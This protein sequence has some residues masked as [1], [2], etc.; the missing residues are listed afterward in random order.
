MSKSIKISP[1]HG[2]NP[3]I[4]KCFWCGESKNQIA[5]M[6]MLPDDAEAPKNLV[7]DFEPCDKCKEEMA[8][9][10][11]L[12]A[13]DTTPLFK[14]QPPAGQDENGNNFYL[15]PHYMVATEGFIRRNWPKEMADHVTAVRKCFMPLSE[16]QYL[17]EEMK[18]LEAQEP[19]DNAQKGE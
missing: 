6:G 19:D 7:A 2:V 16:I 10:I 1:K 11:T 9:G 13:V 14:N 18:K 3:T 5:L 8:K 4:M 17:T 12:M 15:Q